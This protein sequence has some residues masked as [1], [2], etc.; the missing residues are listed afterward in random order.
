MVSLAP[1]FWVQSLQA[2]QVNCVGVL[3]EEQV[4][5][6]GV[7]ESVGGQEGLQSNSK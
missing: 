1:M 2:I 4:L 3:T 7:T 5:P 6:K